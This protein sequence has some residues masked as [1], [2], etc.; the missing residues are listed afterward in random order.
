MTPI[1]IFALLK[2]HGEGKFLDIV[3]FNGNNFGAC[4][5]VGVSPVWEI[6]PDTDEFFYVLEGQFEI[7]LLQGNET[8]HQVVTAGSVFV[9]PQ[10]V[11]HKPGAPG[12]AKFLCFTPGR[13]LHSDEERPDAL[14]IDELN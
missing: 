8:H 12:G 4:D 1:D 14:P 6:H 7:T 5:L 13:S 10:G 3:T 9:V 2:E 11:W